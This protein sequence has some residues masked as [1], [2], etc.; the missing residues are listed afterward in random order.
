MSSSARTPGVRSASTPPALP[1]RNSRQSLDHDADIEID[2]EAGTGSAAPP[3]VS[4]RLPVP[5]PARSRTWSLTSAPADIPL[6]A[7]LRMATSRG[8]ATAAHGA[9]PTTASGNGVRT[10]WLYTKMPAS[11]TLRVVAWRLGKTFLT[12]YAA[13]DEPVVSFALEELVWRK[14]GVYGIEFGVAPAWRHRSMGGDSDEEV[15]PWGAQVV[16]SAPPVGFEDVDPVVWASV[17]GGRPVSPFADPEYVEGFRLYC[18]D[19]REIAQWWEYVAFC[20][21][22]LYARSHV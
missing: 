19:A 14:D 21:F 6:D 22:P 15:V 9:P 17:S 11:D 7:S 10:R 3:P 5:L 8:P 16:A 20:F 18:E 12:C 4:R 1:A 2:L 13:L